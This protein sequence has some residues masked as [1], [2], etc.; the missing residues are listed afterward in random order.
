MVQKPHADIRVGVEHEE[1]P[2]KVA[3][4]AGE[5]QIWMRF[6]EARGTVQAIIEMGGA[7]VA[8]QCACRHWIKWGSF[9]CAEPTHAVP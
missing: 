9:Q 1:L 2:P 7:P 4:G 3:H 8:R 5:L 6:G